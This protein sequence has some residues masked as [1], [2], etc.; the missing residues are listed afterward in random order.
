MRLDSGSVRH[1]LV[2]GCQY[3]QN[4]SK[5]SPFLWEGESGK[6]EQSRGAPELSRERPGVLRDTLAARECT[7]HPE[8]CQGRAGLGR[9]MWRRGGTAG[10]QRFSW[11]LFRAK[12]C[13]HG[14]SRFLNLLPSLARQPGSTYFTQGGCYQP[15]LG[16]P[17]SSWTV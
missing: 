10:V 3:L 8:T 4:Y 16:S 5:D 12:D 14:G 9:T 6:R 2:G 7:G 1:F 17:L 11:S 15:V 13:F